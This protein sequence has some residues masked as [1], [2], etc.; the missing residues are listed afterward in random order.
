MRYAT[1]ITWCINSMIEYVDLGEIPSLRKICDYV[2]KQRNEYAA[3][4]HINP[5]KVFDFSYA[6]FYGMMP[7]LGYTFG[8][9]STDRDQLKPKKKSGLV[10]NANVRRAF[11]RNDDDDDLIV[12]FFA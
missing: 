5:G 2:L 11:A 9:P 3:R 6:N 1:S 10:L 7:R 4:H 12:F 8:A